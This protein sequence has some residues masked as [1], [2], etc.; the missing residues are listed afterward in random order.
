MK[1]SKLTEIKDIRTVWSHEAT[2]FTKWLADDENISILG[3]ELGFTLIEVETEKKVGKFWLDIFAIDDESKTNVAI[4]N[5]LEDTN[6]D[7][8]GKIITYASGVEAKKIIWI[9]KNVRDEHSAAINWLNENT[10]SDISFFLVKIKLFQIDNSAP[11]PKFEVICKPDNWSKNVKAVNTGEMIEREKLRIDFWQGLIDFPNSPHSHRKPT[12]NHW[13][14]FR[15]GNSILNGCFLTSR[16]K[17]RGAATEVGVNNLSY[18][19]NILENKKNI[20]S[21]LGFKI[22]IVKRST[23]FIITTSYKYSINNHEKW[24]EIYEWYLETFEKMKLV[25]PKY[26][27]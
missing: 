14:D 26:F 23:T 1:L 18:Y 9:V 8:L 6:H 21:E 7:H 15:F 10:N 27:E 19:E 24:N 17:P 11:A 4:E 20:E 13:L 2:D 16:M 5:Q 22:D 12:R 3:D 25:L